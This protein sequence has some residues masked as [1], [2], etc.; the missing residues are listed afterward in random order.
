MCFETQAGDEL[1]RLEAQ[2]ELAQ[3][4]FII[5]PLSRLPFRLRSAPQVTNPRRHLDGPTM[6]KH[7]ATQ[8]QH[9]VP[10]QSTSGGRP[11][12]GPMLSSTPHPI[13]LPPADLP[14]GSITECQKSSITRSHWREQSRPLPEPRPH[15]CGASPLVVAP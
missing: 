9:G 12:S 1:P 4:S 13:R 14:R 6:E 11:Y 7:G 15:S 5:C 8:D 3:A 2:S 10:A